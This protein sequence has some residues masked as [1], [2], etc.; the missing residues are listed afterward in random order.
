MSEVIVCGS[1]GG[2]GIGAGHRCECTR[3]RGHAL[4]NDRPHGCPCG[5]PWICAECEHADPADGCAECGA[6]P[7]VAGA[8]IHTEGGPNE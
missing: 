1:D 7:V 3:T 5:A 2:Q 8:L 6:A 4:D